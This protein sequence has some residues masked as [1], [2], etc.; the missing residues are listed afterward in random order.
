M[1]KKLAID[2]EATF[3]KIDK[4]ESGQL[5]FNEFL[6]FA[7]MEFGLITDEDIIQVQAQ[8]EQMDADQSGFVSKEEVLNFYEY[9]REKDE[10]KVNS[11]AVVRVARLTHIAHG[12]HHD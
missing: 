12:L 3:K 2:I 5:D 4:D 6:Q 1:S 10:E 9:A 11:N 8:F 7:L